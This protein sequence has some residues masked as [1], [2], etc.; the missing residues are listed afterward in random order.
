MQ[1]LQTLSTCKY[2]SSSVDMNMASS[3]R[4]CRSFNKHAGS[5]FRQRAASHTRRSF[6]IQ[7]WGAGVRSTARHT[8]THHNPPGVQPAL[9]KSVVDNRLLLLSAGSAASNPILPLR[10]GTRCCASP[11]NALILS[12]S[13]ARRVSSVITLMLSTE[14]LGECL[15]SPASFAHLR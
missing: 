13:N 9:I 5:A 4:A 15:A 12:A 6:G 14:K 3:V 8:T 2:G 10:T 1:K 11:S 7:S